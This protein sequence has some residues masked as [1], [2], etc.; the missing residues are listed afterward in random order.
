[1][2]RRVPVLVVGGFLGSGKTTLVRHLLADAQATGVRMAVI[3]N[4]FG[5]LGIDAALL[6][7]GNVQM[8]ELAGGC[9]C[10]T[11]SNELLETLQELRERVDPDRIVIE[12]SG[13]ALPFDTQLHLFRPPVRDWVGDE[14]CVVVV[15]AE[16]ADESDPLF[17]E[18]VQSADVVVLNK[19]DLIDDAAR[20]TAEAR[21]RTLA[22]GAPLIGCVRSAVAPELCF[23]AGPRRPRCDQHEHHDH[24]HHHHDEWESGE[25]RVPDGLAEAEAWSWIHLRRGVRTKGF[26]RVQEGVRVVQG[27]AQRLELVVAGSDVAPELLG[28]VVVIQRRPQAWILAG[29]RSSRFGSDKAGFVID[30]E[31]LLAR[32]ARVCGDA[33]WV[34]DVVARHERPGGLRTL[35]EPEG[36]RHPLWGVASALSEAVARNQRAALLVPVDLP[37]LSAAALRALMAES[38]PRHA[39]GQPLLAHLPTH[40]AELAAAYARRGA[41]VRAFLDEAGSVA[42][43]VGA[44]DNLNQPSTAAA[45]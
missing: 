33:G 21:I 14:A 2:N 25:L 8:V 18:Q 30:G 45:P 35:V 29:G 41:S 4:E 17:A 19:L 12:T 43:D 37:N 44:L 9:V 36:P 23:P 20:L 38:A 26:V 22:P 40:L 39:A 5:E 24:D 1:M 27:V 34:A 31:T 3:S 28:R 13:L 7:T 42:T 11:L 32:T 15:D 6:G 10:C 16:R